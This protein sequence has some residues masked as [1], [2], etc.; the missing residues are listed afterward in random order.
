[1]TE[2][3]E[4]D[5]NALKNGLNRL[6]QTIQ[7]REAAK[8]YQFVLWGNAARG[9]PNEFA[10]SALFAA[11][12]PNAAQFVKQQTIFSQNGFTITFTGKRLTQSDLDVFEGVMHMARGTHEGN[13]IRFRARQLLCLIG[14]NTGKAEYRWLLGVL[15]CLTATSVAVHR[16]GYQVFWGSL[17]PK[18]AARLDDGFFSVEINRDLI[19]LFTRGYT[20]IQWEQRRQLLRKPLAQAL[21]VWISSHNP[22]PHPVTVEYLRNLTGSDFKELKGFRRGLKV[23]L[24]AI[25]TTGAITAWE[26]DEADK[27]HITKP[28]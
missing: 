27:V 23:A 21:H 8:I 25:K 2:S 19:K 14:R 1:M 10:R 6:N 4:T 20:V 26:I 12:Q 18:G 16:D 7:Q 5:P 17:L 11:I 3:E 28:A 22:K 9:V 24:D 15:E 13:A